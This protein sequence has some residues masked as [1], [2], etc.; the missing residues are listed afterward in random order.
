METEAEVFAALAAAGMALGI[1]RPPA[2]I[3]CGEGTRQMGQNTGLCDGLLF[4]SSS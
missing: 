3:G 1:V 2:S 4:H